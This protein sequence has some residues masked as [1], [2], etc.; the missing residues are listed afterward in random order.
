[1]LIEVSSSNGGGKPVTLFT[2]EFVPVGRQVEY[3]RRS[4]ITFV[5]SVD[6]QNERG[7]PLKSDGGHDEQEVAARRQARC[8]RSLGLHLAPARVLWHGNR[9]GEG[10]DVGREHGIARL[11]TD[12]L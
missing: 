6:W 10:S 9:S 1:M 7:G 11:G 4:A 3:V 12:R 2:R 5:H 8:W